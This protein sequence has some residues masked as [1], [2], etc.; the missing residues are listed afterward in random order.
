MSLT[1]IRFPF[2]EAPW[3]WAAAY[4]SP[5]AGALATPTT[6][7]PSTWSAISVAHTGIARA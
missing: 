4:R 2:I 3:P 1:R 7:A 6:S 5:S